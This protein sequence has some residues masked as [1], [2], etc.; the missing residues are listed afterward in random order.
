MGVWADE[1]RAKSTTG[2]GPVI[3]TGDV[4]LVVSPFGADAA[5]LKALCPEAKQIIVVVDF[6]AMSDPGGLLH[7]VRWDATGNRGFSPKGQCAIKSAVQAGTRIAVFLQPFDSASGRLMLALRRS[8]LT[9]ALFEEQG[10][11]R[12]VSLAIA[13][14]RKVIRT[15]RGRA[16]SGTRVEASTEHARAIEAFSRYGKEGVAATQSEGGIVHYIGTLNSGG[17]ERQLVNLAASLKARRHDVGVFTT[18]LLEGPHGHYLPDLRTGGIEAR[19]AGTRSATGAEKSCIHDVLSDSAQLRAILSS[20]PASLQTSVLDLWGELVVRPPAVLHAWLDEPNIIGG[21]AGVLAG[22]PRIVL[23]ARNYAPAHFPGLFQP[24]MHAWYRAIVICPGVTL[25]ANS[26]GGAADYAQWLGIDS[27]SVVVVPNGVDLSMVRRPPVDSLQA[28]RHSLGITMDQ[29]VV[30]GVFR[31]AV[32]KHP[33]VFVRAMEKVC[34]EIPQARAVIAGIGPL[35]SQVRRQISKSGLD[36]HVLLLGQRKDAV[37][38]I[39]ASDALLLTSFREGMPNCVLEAFAVDTPVVATA[40][41]GTTEVVE[42][43]VTGLLT[44]VGDVHGLAQRVIRVLHD[45]ALAG[46]LAAN[47]RSVMEAR[48]SMDALTAIMEHTYGA[49]APARG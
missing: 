21:I 32:E 48:Y 34:R 2:A 14:A 9:H 40:G 12:R 41:G 24:W 6:D 47:A 11:W 44:D 5:R 13:A 45:Q 20:L 30:A 35:E 46:R 43:E 49:A 17:A 29:K 33:E 27:S 10:R 23:A 36:D 37:D 28:L 39:A 15:I 7:C 18:H 42:D 19:Q 25:L 3:R 16:V 4:T 31:L 38:I 1:F 8:G 26:Q 22:V